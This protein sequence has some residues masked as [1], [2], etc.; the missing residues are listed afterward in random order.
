MTTACPPFLSVIIH[1]G[2]VHSC[3]RF[4]SYEVEITTKEKNLAVR[5]ER[6]E[7]VAHSFKSLSNHAGI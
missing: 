7:L 4:S 1:W 5:Q 2:K 3:V 6:H